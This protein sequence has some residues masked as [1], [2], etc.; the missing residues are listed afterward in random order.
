[1]ASTA[2]QNA[3]SSSSANAS[4]NSTAPSSEIALL[5]ITALYPKQIT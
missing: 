3:T 4:T 1:M 2:E 5:L